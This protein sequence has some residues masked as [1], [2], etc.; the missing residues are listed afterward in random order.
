[1]RSC[2]PRA[3]DWK[4]VMPKPTWI[5]RRT[6]GSS[7]I[8]VFPT[9]VWGPSFQDARM[10]FRD[11][12]RAHPRRAKAHMQEMSESHTHPRNNKN[13]LR[14][15]PPELNAF[16]RCHDKPLPHTHPSLCQESALCGY[17]SKLLQFA[18]VKFH[19]PA[20][21]RKRSICWKTDSC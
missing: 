19:R 18:A 17:C 13:K 10:C 6:S 4:P 3:G 20:V 12:T 9:E 8:T 7:S 21:L 14:D 2:L 1:M 11:P 5:S 16:I 15:W